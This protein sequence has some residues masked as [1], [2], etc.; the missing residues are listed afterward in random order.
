M[1]YVLA[2]SIKG[3][4]RIDWRPSACVAPISRGVDHHASRRSSHRADGISVI[5]CLGMDVELITRLIRAMNDEEVEYIVFGGAALNI[6]GLARFT[7]DVDLFIAP[8]EQNIERLKR[9]LHRVFDDPH[10]DEISAG[11]LLGDYPAVQYVPPEGAFHVDILTRLG[12][13]FAYDDLEGERVEFNGVEL[14]VAT[15][16]TLYRMKKDTLRLKDRADAEALRYA[17]ELG[18]EEG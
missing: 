3:H 14:R 11:D 18:D 15:P 1:R 9:A 10:I 8:T 2:K 17:F 12:E 4:F 6:W 5:R 16:R 13:A 7:Q